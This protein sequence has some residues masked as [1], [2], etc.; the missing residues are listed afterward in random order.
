M[1][2]LSRRQFLKFAGITAVVSQLPDLTGWAAPASIHGRVLQ[3]ARVYRQPAITSAVTHHVWPDSV[4]LLHEA[5]KAW[6]RV[7]DGF[8]QRHLM[9]PINLN[10]TPAPVPQLPFWAEV[11]AP[12]APVWQWC[13]VDAPLITRIGHGGV[14]H[15]IDQLPGWYGIAAENGEFLGWSQSTNWWPVPPANSTGPIHVK[16]ENSHMTVSSAN[17]RLMT[18]PVS[19]GGTVTRGTYALQKGQM[20]GIC[21]RVPHQSDY[22]GAAWQLRFGNNL[23]LTSVYWHNRFGQVV[24]GPAVQVSPIVGRILYRAAHDGSTITFQ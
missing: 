15:I 16:I 13:A 20:G 24:P 6:Y 5:D 10:F 3:A 7:E 18:A 17:H 22:H 8:I 1:P 2:P 12:I 23:D 9:Q 14:V 11:S 4:H 21:C 19:L